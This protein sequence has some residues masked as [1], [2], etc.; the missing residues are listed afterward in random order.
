M[1]L[2]TDFDIF[3]FNLKST[4]FRRIYEDFFL[5]TIFDWGKLR[6]V[7]YAFKVWTVQ[8]SFRIVVTACHLQDDSGTEMPQ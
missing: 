4:V 7:E 8:L 1:G 5:L 6:G 3:V 2:W